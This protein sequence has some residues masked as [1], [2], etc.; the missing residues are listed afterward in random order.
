VQPAAGAACED[1][2]FAGL[3]CEGHENLV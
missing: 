2:A 3:R 1:D